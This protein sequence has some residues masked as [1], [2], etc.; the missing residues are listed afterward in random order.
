MIG[1]GGASGFSPAR[2]EQVQRDDAGAFMTRQLKITLAV[3]AHIVLTANNISG[4][5]KVH[6][7]KCAPGNVQAGHYDSDAKPVLRVVSG[8]VVRVETCSGAPDD[9]LVSPS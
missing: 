6:E 2:S 7:L 9:P 8:D 5:A 4:Q 3:A 1:F